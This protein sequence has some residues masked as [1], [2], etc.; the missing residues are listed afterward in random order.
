MASGEQPPDASAV[1]KRYAAR[2]VRQRH[3]LHVR[4]PAGPDRTQRP[5][6]GPS[7][8]PLHIAHGGV[9]FSRQ[10]HAVR[11]SGRG[12]RRSRRRGQRRVGRREL[13]NVYVHA[14]EPVPVQR[15]P[16]LPVPPLHDVTVFFI[17]IQSAEQASGLL[18]DSLRQIQKIDKTP[19]KHWLD[20]VPA[21]RRRY[22]IDPMLVQCW[23]TGTSDSSQVKN[24]MTKP[25]LV[26]I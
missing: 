13:P 11:W 2:P 25:I 8:Q 19:D 18:T 3:V 12:R 22:H 9:Q 24:A 10:P 26:F 17:R 5:A 14:V 1:R 21:S 6:L 16:E 7:L 15:V 23:Y 4:Q 20:V